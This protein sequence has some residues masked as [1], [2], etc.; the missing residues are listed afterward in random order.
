MCCADFRPVGALRAP[1]RTS[2][3]CHHSDDARDLRTSFSCDWRGPLRSGLARMEGIV[4]ATDGEDPSSGTLPGRR[5]RSPRTGTSHGSLVRTPGGDDPLHGPGFA[6][7]VPNGGYVWWYIDALSDDGLQGLTLIAFIGSVFSP[8]YAWARRRGL[9]DPRNHCAMNLALYGGA[10]NRWAM[11]ERGSRALQRGSDHLSIG[12]SRLIWDE[13]VVTA[14]IDEVTVPIPS[15]L[16]GRIRLYPEAL[17]GRGFALD[18]QGRHCWWPLAPRARVDVKFR[19]PGI[20]WRGSGY[21]DCNAGVL[22][23]EDSFVNWHWSRAHLRRGA[24]ILYNA[25]TRRGEK[26]QL[27][28]RMGVDGV[29]ENLPV[30]PEVRLSRSLWRI[31]RRT[32]ADR[33]GCTRISRSLEDTPFYARSLLKT[34]LLG[35]EIT[36]VHESLDLNRF[37]APWVQMLLP[38]RMPRRA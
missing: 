6:A 24:A 36:A 3:G 20:R 19:R 5:Q 25:E 12:G 18:P 31:T 30:P 13:G 11:T 37:R 2:R 7:T 17:T 21:F 22:P 14:E 33:D 32:Y 16:Q 34:K 1:D 9:V 38:F 35:E 27:A 15:R 8:Y 23:L 10:R 4:C 29:I 26:T 28:L